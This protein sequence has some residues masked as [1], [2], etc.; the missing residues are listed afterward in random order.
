[1]IFQLFTTGSGFRGC[2]HRNTV[3]SKLHLRLLP[4]DCANELFTFQPGARANLAALEKAAFLWTANK[5][6]A[7]EST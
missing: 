2:T 3:K 7:S 5:S 4:S 6:G 1:M